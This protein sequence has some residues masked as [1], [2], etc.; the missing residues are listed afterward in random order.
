MRIAVSGSTGLIGSEIVRYF[1]GKGHEVIRIIRPVTKLKKTESRVILWD[2]EKENINAS[3]LEGF[4][5]IIHLAGANIAS[6]QWTSRYKEIIRESRIRGTTFL[7]DTLARL[8]IPP[9]VFFCASAVG[10][11][12]THDNSTIV[13]ESFP[14]GTGFLAEVCDLWEKS[15][16]SAR[17][18]GIRT[19]HLRFGMVLSRWG[20]ALA[21][22]LSFF[23]FGLG[24]KIGSGRQPVSWITLEE[25]PHIIEFI[26]QKENMQG[27]V[28]ITSPEPVTNAEFSKLL[29]AM[30]HR[31]CLFPLP[32]FLAESIFGEEM[33]RELILNGVRAIPRYLMDEGYSFQYPGIRAG[34]A[35][36]IF[37]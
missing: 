8:K 4:D 9:K 31:P 16:E 5:A 14:L 25:I 13:D 24:G 30:L 22:M 26:F 17:V 33:A 28:N 23:R 18:K 3:L 15:A 20:G 11:Y 19:V 34:L 32:G 12:G 10:Y 35:K 6:A 21:R 2:I 36:A 29:A 1:R 27:P 7:S 37:G